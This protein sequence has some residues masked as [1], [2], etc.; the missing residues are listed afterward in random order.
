MKKNIFLLIIVSGVFFAND[1]YSYSH[2]LS[3]AAKDKISKLVSSD[4][5]LIKVQSLE[6]TLPFSISRTNFSSIF[7]GIY[8]SNNYSSSNYFI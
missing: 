1:V 5:D 6:D 4:L 3:P 8:F 7:S 2:F